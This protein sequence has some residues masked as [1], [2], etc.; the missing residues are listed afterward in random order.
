MG[1][2]DTISINASGLS[3]QRLRM[4]VISNNVA[5]INTTR[6]SDGGSFKKSYVV[7]RSKEPHLN[8]RSH[9]LPE[10]LRVQEGK[11][12]DIVS[13]QKSDKPGRLQYDPN[14]PDAYV[15]GEKKGYVEYSNVNLVEEMVDMIDASRAYEANL[16]L[17]NSAK[18]M[19]M[20]SI[21]IGA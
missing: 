21:N 8:F 20:K 18:Q 4:D 12:V 13:I 3:A 9:V 16:T 19:F 5:N 10:A 11:G 7:L 6:T 14:H 15:A 1:M 17:M 2:F